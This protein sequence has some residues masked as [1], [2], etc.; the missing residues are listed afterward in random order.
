M[1]F[2]KDCFT[3]FKICCATLV[4]KINWTTEDVTDPKDLDTVRAK[5]KDNYYI[6]L[7]RH[8]GH[9]STFAIALAHFLVTGRW[10][11]YS[12]VLL[13]IEDE[14]KTDDDYEFLQSTIAG[15]KYAKFDEVFDQQGGS[16]ALVKPRYVTLDEWTHILDKSRTNIGKPYDLAMDPSQDAKLNCVEL[17]RNSLQGDPDY[18]TDFANLEAKIAKYKALDPQM[19]YECPD[20]EV[21]W[22]KRVK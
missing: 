20:F 3:K 8:E 15:V 18:A 10:G 5:L 7:T 13:N 21:V 9:L 4:G 2:F 12:H 14:V 19:I 6:I 11:Y 22:E 16:I 1:S 17:V